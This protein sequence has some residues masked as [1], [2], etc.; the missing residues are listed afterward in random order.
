MS[1]INNNDHVVVDAVLDKKVL[2]NQ[3]SL[4]YSAWEQDKDG[5]NAD[6]WMGVAA[7]LFHLH[8][9]SFILKQQITKAN[10]DVY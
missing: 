7:L 10:R 1:E 3:A 2:L 9:G 8:D 6:L 5:P 4:C